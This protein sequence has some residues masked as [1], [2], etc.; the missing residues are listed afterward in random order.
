MGLVTR[1]LH[2]RVII[3][4]GCHDSTQR[5]FRSIQPFP[6]ERVFPRWFAIGARRCITPAAVVAVSFS[7][8]GGLARGHGGYHEELQRTDDEIAAHPHDG[9]HWYRRGLL[10]VLHGE[11]Q[12]ALVD[13]ERADRLEPGKY[14]TDWLRAQALM[15]GGRFEAAKS[16]LDDFVTKHPLHAG[17]RAARARVLE[18]LKQHRAALEDF[19]AAVIN[20]QNPEPDLLI[21]VAEAL[22]T[23]KHTDEA[24]DLIELHL[25]R[26]GH[27]PGLVMKALE[28][29]VAL[30]R[31]DAALSRVDAMQKSAPRP[32]PWMAKRAD[33]LEQ[34]GRADDARAAWMALRDHILAL[35]NLERGA[36]SMSRILEQAQIALGTIK[37]APAPS[38]TSLSSAKP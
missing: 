1:L 33:V 26:I 16:V 17:A 38:I 25:K 2:R 24:A 18:K 11:W 10:N 37:P 14:A 35:P 13:L 21:E 22:V 4:F 30:G 34:C 32:E 3:P 8:L 29:D 5:C 9:Q 27:S 12:T 6:C 23:Q 36:H 15:A 31:I 19:R 20:T 28:L 7:L